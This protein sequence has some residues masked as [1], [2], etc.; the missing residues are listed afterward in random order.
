M[1]GNSFTLDPEAKTN[2]LLSDSWFRSQQ[3]GLEPTTDD[4]PRLRSNELAD[5][6]ASHTRL[7]QLTQPV[8][9]TLSRKVADLQSVVILSDASGLVL[10]TFGNLHAM[11]KAQSFALAPGNLWSESGRGTNAIG[12]ALAI[13]DS[14]EID[15]R[16]HFLTSN[17]DLYCAAMPVQSPDGKIA[18][19]LDIS[20]PAQVPHP[21]TLAWVKAAAKQI[22]YLWVKQSLHP[23]QWL[24]SLH[25]DPHKLDSVEELLLVFSDNVLTAG[26][27]LA[28]R[29]LGLDPEQFGQVT[30]QQLFPQLTQT[31]VSIPLPVTLQQHTCYYRLRAPARS[32][33]AVVAPPPAP[34]PE[35]LHLPFT[36]P[37]EGEKLLRLLNAGIALCIE[38]ETGCGKEFVSRT[39]HQHSRWRNGKFVAINCA[40][41]PESLIESELF[42]YQPGAFTGASKNGYIG[43]IREA[44]GGVLFLDEI[45]DMPMLLQTRLLRVLQEKEVTPLGASRSAAVSFAVICATHRNL[46]Q[47]VTEG[48]FREDLLYRLREFALTIPPLREW[49]TLPAFIQQLW[50]D[51]GATA[52]HVQLSP[53][54]LTHLASL[55]WPGNVRQ[56]QSL[57]KVLLAL[58]DEGDE[59]TVADL[60]AEYQTAPPPL[61]SRGLQQHDAQL[62]AQTLSTFNGNVSKTA[63]ALGVARSTLYRRAAR[64]GKN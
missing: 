37:Q 18:G 55:P 31:A 35:P 45:G 54:L 27:R 30:F 49:T 51:L 64:H 56:L 6:L 11:E 60:P 59:L 23:Q 4:F 43:K 17:Q 34:E 1:Q 7:Q 57:M 32:G 50:H 58:A 19:V 26:N 42:G 20:G 16:Q 63:Q 29:D 40:A 22:E 61:P 12:T 15:G 33:V 2:P 8:V 9:N 44:D 38:G 24:M 46:A 39:L 52:R 10:Q 36:S 5:V 25:A 3:Y 48:T 28:M 47:H 62:I 41:I 21:H 14:C 13:D 53:P